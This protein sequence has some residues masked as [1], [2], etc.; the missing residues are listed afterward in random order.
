MSR[1]LGAQRI[2]RYPQEYFAVASSLRDSHA[3][4]Q[5]M[6]HRLSRRERVDREVRLFVRGELVSVVKAE[7]ISPE[8]IFLAVSDTLFQPG[9]CVQMQIR[10]MDG[11]WPETRRRGLIVHRANGGLGVMF[12]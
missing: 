5:P 11:H 2:E 10:T 8:G 9:M 4:P 6:E 7:N 3:R 1:E 12:A